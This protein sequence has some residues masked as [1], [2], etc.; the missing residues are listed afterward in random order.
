MPGFK[1]KYLANYTLLTG[2]DIFANCLKV[3]KIN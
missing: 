1:D 2:S 3:G